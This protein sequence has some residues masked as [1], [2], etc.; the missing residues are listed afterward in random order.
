MPSSYRWK[1]KQELDQA[2]DNIQK[3]MD[4]ITLTGTEF[5]DPHPDYYEQFCAV[6][7]G[8]DKLKQWLHEINNNI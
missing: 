1:I 2:E 6:V 4:R 3:A 5:K 8:L 7:Q